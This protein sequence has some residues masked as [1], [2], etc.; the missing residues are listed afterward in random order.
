MSL[1]INGQG[2]RASSRQS[3]RS[4]RNSAAE[5]EEVKDEEVI[6][7]P[8]PEDEEEQA[9]HREE[10]PEGQGQQQEIVNALVPGLN[11]QN[12][13]QQPAAVNVVQVAVK[14]PNITTL[15]KKL[16]TLTHGGFTAWHSALQDI[17][18]YRN[19]DG[20]VLNQPWN[21]QEETNAVLNQQRR[22]AYWVIMNTIPLGTDY[23]HLATGVTRGDANGL[24]KKIYKLFLE[25]TA[26]NRGEIR[27]KFYDLS[28]ASTKLNVTK[29]AAKVVQVAQD[30]EAVGGRL[31]TD[32]VVT[33]FLDGLSKKFEPIV[34]VENTQH[35]SFEDTL[36]NVVKFAQKNKLLEYRETSVHGHYH[37][38]K[39]SNQ[40]KNE[41]TM[42]HNAPQKKHFKKKTKPS[43][44]FKRWSSQP[45]TTSFGP[46]QQ[47]GNVHQQEP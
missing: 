47:K 11:R 4:R 24:Y 40:N 6:V 7:D 43:P 26:A 28:M 45:S 39:D 5:E 34:T 8:N 33:R 41:A 23:H 22:D 19:W 20:S 29:F 37:L 10:A 31:D 16:V 32:E 3:S 9:T 14:L 38:A 30:L 15:E 12:A 13:I 42:R 27:K 21:G 36:T 2:S 1:I 18:Y 46:S 17:A 35:N 44:Q 25:S